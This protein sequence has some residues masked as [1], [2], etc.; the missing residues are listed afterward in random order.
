MPAP[1]AMVSA[2]CFAT[3]SPG[4]MAAAMPPCA[5]AE[6][7]PSPIGAAASTVTGRGARRRAANSPA[8]PP[9]RMITSSVSERAPERMVVATILSSLSARSAPE[10]DHAFHR[11]A[12][13]LRNL[14]IDGHLV[15]EID[16]AVEDLRQG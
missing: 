10:V 2:R 1:A 13:L 14:R 7:A 6:E 3:E 5:H 11:A 15:F 9:P 8:S 16:E 12:G 4:A